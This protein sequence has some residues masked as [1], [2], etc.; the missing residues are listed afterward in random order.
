MAAGNLGTRLS[1]WAVSTEAAQIHR[2]VGIGGH[3]LT[4][5]R[6]WC[7]G[8]HA[9]GGMGHAC[10]AT[11]PAPHV[12]VGLATCWCLRSCRS[13]LTSG[14]DHIFVRHVA[15]Q[16][17][18]WEGPPQGSSAPLPGMHPVVAIAVVLWNGQAPMGQYNCLPQDL[19]QLRTG[20]CECG[21]L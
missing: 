18:C 3:C 12:A 2:K 7:W 4:P 17:S 5:N 9:C 16:S 19:H 11:A 1:H 10:A 6:S 15:G 21:H 20:S 14:H 13:G 8:L